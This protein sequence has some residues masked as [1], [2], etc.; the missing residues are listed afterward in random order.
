VLSES[1]RLF[2]GVD[3]AARPSQRADRFDVGV[4][5]G[6]GAAVGTGAGLGR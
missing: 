4:E 6:V 1:R 3:G 2:E 5:E